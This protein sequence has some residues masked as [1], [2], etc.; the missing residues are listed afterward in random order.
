MCIVHDYIKTNVVKTVANY[1]CSLSPSTSPKNACTL[2]RTLVT[3]YHLLF[4]SSCCETVV[5]VLHRKFMN[6][7]KLVTSILLVYLAHLNKIYLLRIH[8]SIGTYMYRLFYVFSEQCNPC[9]QCFMQ[10]SDDIIV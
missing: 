10:F 7:C 9:S 3:M 1:Y 4:Q 5:Y 6:T 2:S 8:V